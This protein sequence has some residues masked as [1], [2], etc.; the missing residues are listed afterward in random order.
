MCGGTVSGGLASKVA[1]AC[2]PES[3]GCAQDKF[4]EG[5]GVVGVG[6]S[7]E[8]SPRFLVAPLLGMT[9]CYK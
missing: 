9:L 3:F 4:R 1:V 2:H 6:L 5:S 8:P 7:G